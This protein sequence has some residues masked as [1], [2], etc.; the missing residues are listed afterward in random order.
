MRHVF[1]MG[2]CRQGWRREG[3]REGGREGEGGDT[4]VTTSTRVTC[5]RMWSNDGT[6]D[7]RKDGHPELCS[8]CT[9][10]MTTASRGI[11]RL[12]DESVSYAAVT[13]LRL[14]TR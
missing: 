4:V 9:K 2:V 3:G 8:L 6:R 13:F 12:S 5:A 1:D 11:G 7:G 10:V 14:A